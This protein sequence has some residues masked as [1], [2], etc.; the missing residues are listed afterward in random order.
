M[1]S[2]RPAVAGRADSVPASGVSLTSV[3]DVAD[4]DADSLAEGSRAP[5]VVGPGD[6]SFASGV[7]I[8]SS[9]NDCSSP[10]AG[11]T[12]V[13]WEASAFPVSAAGAG[14]EVRAVAVVTGAEPLNGGSVVK[15]GAVV[16]IA[17]TVAIDAP[18]TADSGANGMKRL[19]IVKVRRLKSAH[20]GH[21]RITSTIIGKNKIIGPMIGSKASGIG[22]SAAAVA[23][24]AA[25]S[26]CRPVAAGS[27][28]DRVVAPPVCVRAVR[29]IAVEMSAAPTRAAG[30]MEP[31]VRT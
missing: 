2:G 9:V 14:S 28:S 20:G 3:V 11:A 5:T 24:S 16:V 19:G 23:A 21:A 15:V 22:G 31:S 6:S 7:S 29:T 4:P 12:D 30:L 1:G 13:N 8:A 10:V 26:T 27:I 25:L 18:E 17:S